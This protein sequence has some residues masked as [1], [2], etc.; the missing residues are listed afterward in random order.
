MRSLIQRGPDD[1]GAA[2]WRAVV[3]LTVAGIAVGLIVN[4]I[5]LATRS[6]RALAWTPVER[7]LAQLDTTET[8]AVPESAAIQRPAPE[9]MSPPPPSPPSSSSSA[10]AAT[11]G[12]TPPRTAAG[13]T[14]SSSAPP[15]TPA[16]AN[17]AGLPAVPDSRDPVEIH[18]ADVHR[19][20]AAGAA[21]FIDAREAG[22]YAAGHIAGAISIPFDEAFKNPKLASD[23]DAKGRPIIVYC[24]GGDCEASKNL[25]YQLL[26][27]GKKKVLV[28]TDGMPAWESAGYPVTRGTTP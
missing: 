14:P 26:D 15:S 2:L 24:S 17:T 1:S 8:A 21:L 28:F 12:V 18:T 9:S 25:A 20:H 13:A 22:E 19:F 23:V 11:P 5:A 6:P 4:A 10:K 7:A 3:L 16:P 27:A